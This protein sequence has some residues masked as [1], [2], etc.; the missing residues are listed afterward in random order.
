MTCGVPNVLVPQIGGQAAARRLGT[1]WCVRG[2]V[3]LRAAGQEGI[4]ALSRRLRLEGDTSLLV[5]W[6][7]RT[8]GPHPRVELPRRAAERAAT[9]EPRCP[10]VRARAQ[11]DGGLCLLVVPRR[12][13]G[14]SAGM[15]NVH[16]NLNGVS[17]E[18]YGH[19]ILLMW[20]DIYE[21]R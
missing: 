10:P 21:K 1:W 7:W 14:F 4:A 18:F 8:G 16:V 19:L 15:H 5:G 3:L 17:W 12:R 20:Y 11:V 2:M 6:R 13:T 9:I